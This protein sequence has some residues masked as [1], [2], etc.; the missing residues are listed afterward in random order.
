MLEAIEKLLILQDRDRRLVRLQNELASI[1]P[2]RSRLQAR[3]VAAQATLDA[4]KH[5]VMHL[6]SERKKLE[7]EVEARKQ[8]IEKYSFQ[9]FQTRKNEEYRALTHE[10]DL[11]K[12]A[13]AEFEDQ[14]LELMEQGETAQKEV[15]AA[16][17]AL[18]ELKHNV[19]K[20][21]ADLA[22]REA[23]LHQQLESARSER[24]QAAAV[25]DESLLP[26]Y[27]RLRKSKGET[28]VVGIDR[29]VCGGCHM[30]IPAQVI[31]HC[32]AGQ[33]IPVCPNCGRILYYTRDM[34][35]AAAE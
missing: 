7:L 26:R 27:E 32:R 1:A 28:V 34:V 13:I 29:G 33:E 16:A 14:Q 20:Q 23:N 15:N 10:I 18:A 24:Q 22:A 12:Q 19:E 31:V 4:A 30:K 25:I 17:K 35:L 9:Q 2:E 21:L 6:E 11:C 8:L 5:R 3:L